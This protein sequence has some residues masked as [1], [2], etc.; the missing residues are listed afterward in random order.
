MRLFTALLWSEEKFSEGK[1]KNFQLYDGP[2]H[3]LHEIQERKVCIV[4]NSFPILISSCP[5]FPLIVVTRG[6]FKAR[7]R[8]S[9]QTAHGQQYSQRFPTPAV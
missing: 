4:H 5:D 9:R 7:Q 1:I 8:E 3:K 6:A 2:A